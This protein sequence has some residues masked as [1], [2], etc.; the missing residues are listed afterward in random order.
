MAKE[1][2]GAGGY[3]AHYLFRDVNAREALNLQR[4]PDFFDGAAL[5]GV[6]RSMLECGQCVEGVHTPVYSYGH[7]QAPHHRKSLDLQIQSLM[8]L[9]IPEQR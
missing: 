2:W 9:H 6:H 1:G 8:R 3:P 4:E 5:D 7:H